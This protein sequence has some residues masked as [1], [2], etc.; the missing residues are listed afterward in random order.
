M[1]Q[2]GN[3]PENTDLPTGK[4]PGNEYVSVVLLFIQEHL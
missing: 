4:T 3:P 1:S 2:L